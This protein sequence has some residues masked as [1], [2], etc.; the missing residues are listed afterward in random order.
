[1][2]KF[3]AMFRGHEVI[4]EYYLMQNGKLDYAIITDDN[5]NFIHPNYEYEELDDFWEEVWNVTQR[6]LKQVVKL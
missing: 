4:I 6:H 5:P 1:M 3:Q 2:G